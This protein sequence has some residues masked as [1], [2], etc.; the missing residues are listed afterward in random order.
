[1]YHKLRSLPYN[2]Q[3][4][5]QLLYVIQVSLAVTNGASCLNLFQPLHILAV[6][7]ASSTPSV[8]NLSNETYKL[9]LYQSH[10]WHS[11]LISHIPYVYQQNKWNSETGQIIWMMHQLHISSSSYLLVSAAER[12]E[13]I[14]SSWSPRNSATLLVSVHPCTSLAEQWH[15]FHSAARPLPDNRQN[16][17][18]HIFSTQQ[19]K[20]FEELVGQP[21]FEKFNL[22]WWQ[23]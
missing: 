19:N 7:S 15:T 13:K 5:T 3:L 1:V 22:H 18:S 23:H 9:D 16:I 21:C 14:T 8:L 6:T 4:L 11:L 10:H 17:Y 20:A 12:L 2:I